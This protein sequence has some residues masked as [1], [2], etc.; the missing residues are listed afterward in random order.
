MSAWPEPTQQFAPLF[1]L[2]RSR[3]LAVLRS[4]EP[5]DWDRPSPCPGWSVLGL[6]THLVGDDLSFLAWQRDDHHGTPPPDGLDEHGF[7]AWLDE[8]QVE[9]VR[10]ARRV[11]TLLEMYL[12]VCLFVM[13]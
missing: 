6:G 11:R 8:L 3:L 2:E 7:I 5:A 1:A 10:A 4:L 12:L 9:W 13:L